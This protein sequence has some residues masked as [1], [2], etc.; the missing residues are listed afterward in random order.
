MLPPH[1]PPYFQLWRRPFLST[2]TYFENNWQVLFVKLLWE[3]WEQLACFWMVWPVQ[4]PHRE[5]FLRVRGCSV[6]VKWQVASGWKPKLDRIKQ[7]GVCV[8]VIQRN[9]SS[10][11][12]ALSLISWCLTLVGRL[13]KRRN[14]EISVIYTLHSVRGKVTWDI[15]AVLLALKSESME[16]IFGQLCES[17]LSGCEIHSTCWAG[18][19]GGV[20][21]KGLSDHF[22][23][24][25]QKTRILWDRMLYSQ[26]CCEICEPVDSC[27]CWLINAYRRGTLIGPLRV[28]LS[29]F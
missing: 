11:N 28:L 6:Q 22:K 2:N 23:G 19:I 16:H 20:A 13:S 3:Q 17:L 14:W 25:V 15:S 18:G 10:E 12:A 24:M 26:G 9:S 8:G 7:K 4:L 27:V 21:E 29:L 5:W 1:R